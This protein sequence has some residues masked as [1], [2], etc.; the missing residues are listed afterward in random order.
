MYFELCDANRS[1]YSFQMICQR[2]CWLWAHCERIYAN[3]LWIISDRK[4]EE[5]ARIRLEQLEGWQCCFFSFVCVHNTRTTHQS[6][7]RWN[8]WKHFHFGF[9]ILQS[10][11]RNS[12][13][14]RNFLFVCL[15]AEKFACIRAKCVR[16]FASIYMH[17]FASIIAIWPRT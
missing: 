2:I 13:V 11:I 15:F 7:I 16:I 5:E 6:E 4:T 14:K 9:S 1:P 10:E 8:S 12:L 17:T 3:E